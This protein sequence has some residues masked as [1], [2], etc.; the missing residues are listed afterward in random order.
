MENLFSDFSEVA[1]RQHQKVRGQGAGVDY[2]PVP[3]FVVLAAKQDVV[4]NRGILYPGLLSNVGHAALDVTV[5]VVTVVMVALRSHDE[6]SRGLGKGI[7]LVIG[8]R[9]L[10]T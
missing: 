4:A 10:H 9:D 5:V 3:G 1:G 2:R 8:S 6:G 7:G